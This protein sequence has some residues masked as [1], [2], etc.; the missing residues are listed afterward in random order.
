MREE[1]ST[2]LLRER[3][4]TRKSVAAAHVPNHTQVVPASQRYF[5]LQVTLNYV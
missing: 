3:T 1:D 5:Q 4:A 2:T